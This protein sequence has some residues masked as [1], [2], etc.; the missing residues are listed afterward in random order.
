VNDD[1]TDTA[2]DVAIAQIL[3]EADHTGAVWSHSSSDLNINVVVIDPQSPVG[4]HINNEVDVVMVVVGGSGLV[5]VGDK[6]IAVTAPQAVIIPKGT[7]RAIRSDDGRLAY[8]TI[9]R[10]R[11]GLW[12][13][14]A[15]TR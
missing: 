10:R 2:T 7:S 6:E 12:P 8:L 13:K 11:A 1:R 5:Q 14:A 9:H 3:A 15:S 4:R